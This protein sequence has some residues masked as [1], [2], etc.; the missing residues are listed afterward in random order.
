MK[1]WI[2]PSNNNSFRLDEFLNEYGYVDWKQRNN[3]EVEDIVFI[4]STHPERKIKF[5]MEVEKINMTF[6]ESTSDEEFWH[7]ADEFIAGKE[8]NRF[9]RF[10]KLSEVGSEK[11]SFGI[12][13]KHGLKGAPQG[14]MKASSVL[15]EYITGVVDSLTI[16]TDFINDS[17][18]S[19]YEG[20]KKQ[21]IVNKYERNPEARKKCIELK[22]CICAVCSMNFEKVYGVL[23]K[24]FI[25][26]HHIVPISTIGESYEINYETDL[27]PVCPNCHAMLHRG[28]N[29][30]V[31][32]VKELKHIIEINGV[33]DI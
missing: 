23:G 4:Y 2:V 13:L 32:T 8:H 27:V 20:V 31:L 30:R 16:D 26:I 10:R 9:C 15:V 5:I 25:H 21:V 6:E 11:L 33:T 14:A 22:G 12:L 24:N 3:Y 28:L 19:I 7:N 18:R 29:G 1:H 17:D